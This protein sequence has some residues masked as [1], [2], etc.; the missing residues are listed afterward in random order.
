MWRGAILGAV[1]AMGSLLV[2]CPIHSVADSTSQ[3]GSVSGWKPN[4]A[5]ARRYARG[6]SGRIDFD[7]IDPQG[8]EY[9][10]HPTRTSP[11]ASTFKVMLL[12]TYLR[13]PSVAHRRL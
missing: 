6:R 13:R 11:M 12:A 3:A 1:L 2:A 5:S 9:G 10:Y 7:V 8:R 4:V